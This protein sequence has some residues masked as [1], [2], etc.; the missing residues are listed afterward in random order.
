[1]KNIKK[2][3]EN[4][5]DLLE[6]QITKL[7]TIIGKLLALRILG[8]LVIVA[9]IVLR[10]FTDFPGNK[11][12]WLIPLI[13]SGVSLVFDM[14]ISDRITA[15]EIPLTWYKNAL[16][17][18]EGKW[19]GR[20]MIHVPDL[21]DHPFAADTDIFGEGSL[22]DLI[23]RARTVKGTDTL[24]SWLSV[25]ATEKEILRRQKAITELA[26]HPDFIE[27]V[28]CMEELGAY[29]KT[30]AVLEGFSS[31]PPVF[32]GRSGYFFSIAA[33]LC[34]FALILSFALWFAGIWTIVV[35][36]VV[37]IPLILLH[38]LTM[39]KVSSISSS[40][41]A[42]A[43]EASSLDS[44][45]RILKNTNFKSEMMMEIKNSM[46]ENKD[47]AGT[48]IRRLRNLTSLAESANNQIWAFFAFILF[49]NLHIAVYTERFRRRYGGLIKTWITRTGEI[50]ALFSLTVFHQENPDSVFPVVEDTSVVSTNECRNPLFLPSQWEPVS[51]TLSNDMRIAI[52]SGSNMSGK[53]SLLR[54]LALN[55]VLAGA[56]CCVTASSF[57]FRPG[58]LVCSIRVL[59]S[60]WR[61][62]S[63]FYAEVK[64]LKTITENARNGSFVFYLIDELFSGTNSED[65]IQGAR[66]LTRVLLESD[67]LGIMTT[68][69]LAITSLEKEFGPNISNFH[70]SDRVENGELVFDYQIRPGKIASSNAVLILEKEGII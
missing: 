22:M 24:G 37:F 70:Y 5:R 59:D 3:Y 8:V 23:C 20:G 44:I 39:N 63:R 32:S 64:K 52:V 2:Y 68:H 4:N 7:K 13:I 34:S 42:A 60:T 1:M 11:L 17:R 56:G 50:E 45:I 48:I 41:K 16:L 31:R 35:P 67:S 53:S 25:C 46:C 15:L 66:R 9:V 69:D 62:I 51:L 43:S 18:I 55:Y 57:R 36:G 47:S 10:I 21:S 61:G 6:K 54:T 33:F 49:Q 26:S 30:G 19:R 38:I 14:F 27:S 58:N 29:D 65:R 12:I 28:I 40:L